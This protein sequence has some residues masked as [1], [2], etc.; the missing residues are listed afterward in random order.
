MLVLVFC[1]LDHVRLMGQMLGRLPP[2]ILKKTEI[3]QPR[4]YDFFS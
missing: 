1:Q 2:K 3:V 4:L